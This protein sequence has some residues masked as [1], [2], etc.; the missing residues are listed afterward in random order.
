MLD[1]ARATRGQSGGNGLAPLY[2]RSHHHFAPGWPEHCPT[3]PPCSR[4]EWSIPRR[5]RTNGSHSGIPRVTQAYCWSSG[6]DPPSDVR[7]TPPRRH[8]RPQFPGSPG[9]PAFSRRQQS[10][11]NVPPCPTLRRFIGQH[12]AECWH[13]KRRCWKFVWDK[14]CCHGQL[15]SWSS[16]G[17]RGP[18]GCTGNLFGFRREPSVTPSHYPPNGGGI[19]TRSAECGGV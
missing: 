14:C 4:R 3:S 12:G 11:P 6:F 2:P 7:P 19:A 9:C 17:F 5:R 10:P 13:C 1:N 16:N 8:N 18:H 15:G